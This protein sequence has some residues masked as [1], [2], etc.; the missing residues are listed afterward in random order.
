[1]LAATL[2]ALAGCSTPIDDGGDGTDTMTGTTTSPTM[3]GPPSCD[4][5]TATIWVDDDGLVHGGPDHGEVD[6][7]DRDRMFFF[8]GTA[9][10]DVIVTWIH[11]AQSVRG[12]GGDDIICLRGPQDR[13]RGGP[14][15]DRIFGGPLG[16]TLSGGDDNDMLDGGPGADGLFGNAGDDILYGGAGDDIL[17][18]GDGTDEAHGGPGVDSCGAETETSCE[19]RWP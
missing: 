15:N 6:T 19:G 10:A 7:P 5:H 18:G 14:G 3:E 13:A 4:G 8:N 1:M 2:V 16:Q 12:E 17:F 11:G 9:G